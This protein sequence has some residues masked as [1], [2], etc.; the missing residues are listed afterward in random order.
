[1]LSIEKAMEKSYMGFARHQ[2][3]YDEN[4]KTVD[5]VFLSVNSSFERMTG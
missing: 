5:F 1:M 3:I 4:K 2:V